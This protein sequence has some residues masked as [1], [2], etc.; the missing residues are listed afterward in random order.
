MSRITNLE[1]W[2]SKAESARA[3]SACGPTSEYY[4]GFQGALGALDAFGGWGSMK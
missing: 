1:G 2:L 3:E 4:R